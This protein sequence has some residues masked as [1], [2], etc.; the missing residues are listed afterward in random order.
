MNR[1]RE[2]LFSGKQYVMDEAHQNY[3][4]SAG[5]ELDF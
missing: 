1:E 5:P 2:K 4:S 3:S